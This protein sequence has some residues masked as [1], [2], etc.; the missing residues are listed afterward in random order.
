MTASVR[1]RTCHYCGVFGPSTKDHIVPRSL[2]GPT[3]PWNLV[4]SCEPCNQAKR[5]DWPTCDCVKCGTARARF[6]KDNPDIAAEYEAARR[7]QVNNDTSYGF[8]RC[9]SVLEVSSSF[10]GQLLAQC[11]KPRGHQ[12]AEHQNGDFTW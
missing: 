6:A 2:G 5:S 7:V 9:A 8:I 3:L 4:Y 1:E 11:V 10:G 12:K